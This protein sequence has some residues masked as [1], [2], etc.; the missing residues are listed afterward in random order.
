MTSRTLKVG[1]LF[2]H[3]ADI[4]TR[5]CIHCGAPAVELDDRTMHFEAAPNGARTAWP[6][7]YTLVRGRRKDIGTTAELAA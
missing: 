6:Q 5:P 3:T 2:T 7:C 4:T 1:D